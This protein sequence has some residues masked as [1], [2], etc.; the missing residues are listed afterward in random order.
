M[1]NEI[2]GTDDLLAVHV[3]QKAADHGYRSRIGAFIQVMPFEAGKTVRDYGKKCL[4]YGW[5]EDQW[6][7]G[8]RAGGWFQ[9]PQGSAPLLK[10]L[11]IESG[12][13]DRWDSIKAALRG[14]PIDLRARYPFLEGVLTDLYNGLSADLVRLSSA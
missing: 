4:E 7:V 1:V 13:I 5:N 2:G 8:V 6:P 11:V 3:T 10:D 12:H 9:V 14:G